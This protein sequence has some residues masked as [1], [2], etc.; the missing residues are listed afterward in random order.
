[1]M[2]KETLEWNEVSKREMEEA[3]EKDGWSQDTLMA[4]IIIT[5][6]S[7]HLHDW[8]KAL[9]PSWDCFHGTKIDT[10]SCL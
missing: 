4:D 7:L 9:Q 8:A 10:T 3:S 6:R 1:M 5:L 2:S